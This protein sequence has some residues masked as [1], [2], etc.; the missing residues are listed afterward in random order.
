MSGRMFSLVSKDDE[1]WGKK[2]YKTKFSYRP[3]INRVQDRA[4]HHSLLD[5]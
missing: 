1:F 4:H 3:Q 5:I 2:L